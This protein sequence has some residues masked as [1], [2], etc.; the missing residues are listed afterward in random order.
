MNSLELSIISANPDEITALEGFDLDCHIHMMTWETAWAELIKVALYQHG[1][2][3]SQIGSSWLSNL[4]AMQ[5]LRP[6]TQRE[7]S[8]LGGPEAF[9]SASWEASLVPGRGRGWVIPWLT[10]VRVIYYWRDMLQEAGVDEQSAF[11]TPAHMEE[12]L[13]RLQTSGV[14]K[15]P[16]IVT[17]QLPLTTL[18]NVASWVWGAGGELVSAR[19]RNALFGEPAALAGARA[20]FGL[21]RYLPPG[22]QHMDIAQVFNLFADRQAAVA[23]GTPNWLQLTRQQN[24]TSPDVLA[25]LGVALP[26]GPPFVGGS[27]L[28]VWRHSRNEW[29]AVDLVRQLLNK[30]NQLEYCQR[31]GYLPARLDVLNEP[32]YSTDPHYQVMVQALEVGRSFPTFRLWGLVEERLSAALNEVWDIILGDPS[33]NLDAV[34]AGQLEPLS[35]RLDE[36]LSGMR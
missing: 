17:L 25:Y 23:M 19:G 9:V 28:I 36:S 33:Q 34:I 10:D 11:Q 35:Q 12:T 16:W 1:P 7:I 14:S 8:S 4:A 22:I 6:F 20:Y 24:S 27:G 21:Q 30:E 29:E 2:D 32:P 26:P 3:V 13:D 18:H 5:G 31:I 15:A